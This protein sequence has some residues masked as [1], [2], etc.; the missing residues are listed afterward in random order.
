VR[1]IARFVKIRVRAKEL[2]LG[3]TRNAFGMLMCLSVGLMAGRG[4]PAVEVLADSPRPIRSAH[5]APS[6]SSFAVTYPEVWGSRVDGVGHAGRVGC[7]AWA[8]ARLSP[9]IKTSFGRRNMT[10]G[11]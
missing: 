8:I 5:P 7:G 6:G 3:T 2:L 11:V 4:L 9:M 10:F 1:A